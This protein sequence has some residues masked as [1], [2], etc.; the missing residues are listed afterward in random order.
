MAIYPI[1][2]NQGIKK[3]SSVAKIGATNYLEKYDRSTFCSGIF[4]DPWRQAE[5]NET[6][7]YELLT[8]FGNQ[9][10]ALRGLR[11]EV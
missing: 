9:C 7:P 6:I 3:G 1:N 4:V 5:A 11:C 8:S 10:S 2:P